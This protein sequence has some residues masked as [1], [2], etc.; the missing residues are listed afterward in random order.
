MMFNAFSCVFMRF[1]LECQ[2]GFSPR[3][4]VLEYGENLPFMDDVLVRYTTL[5]TLSSS[6]LV[7]H[8]FAYAPALIK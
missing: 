4:V 1:L 3:L 7:E 5:P 8:M 2:A 6:P